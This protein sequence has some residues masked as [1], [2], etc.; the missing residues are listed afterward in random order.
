MVAR[1]Q[2]RNTPHFAAPRTGCLACL[3][4]ILIVFCCQEAAAKGKKPPV[5]E[6]QHFAPLCLVRNPNVEKCID[7]TIKI[8]ANGKVHYHG[9]KAMSRGQ[10]QQSVRVLGN[11]YGKITQEQVTELVETFESFP[12]E[13]IEKANKRYGNQGNSEVI[14]YKTNTQNLKINFIPFFNV[15]TTKLNEF[16]NIEKWICFPQGH[17][18]HDRC[19]LTYR[20][21]YDLISKMLQPAVANVPAEARWTRRRR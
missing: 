5:F 18:D 6:L 11:R 1:D 12:L 9:Q 20:P 4:L 19:L 21:K 3:F 15:M 10:M 16:M 14:K 7:F 13:D 8:Y 2:I 17:I